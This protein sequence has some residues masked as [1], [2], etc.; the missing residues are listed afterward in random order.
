MARPRK[1]ST[2]TPTQPNGTDAYARPYRVKRLGSP[3]A[4][5]LQSQIPKALRFPLYT[6]LSLS[7]STLVLQLFAEYYSGGEMGAISQTKNTWPEIGVLVGWRVVELGFVW[8]MGYDGD[9]FSPFIF[10]HLPSPYIPQQLTSFPRP[11]WDAAYFATLTHAPPLSLLNTFYNIRPTV[12]IGHLLIDVLALAI[13]LRL[14]RPLSPVHTTHPP[15]NSVS[16]RGI[17]TDS[18]TALSTALLATSIYALT[19]YAAYSTFL[20]EYM[21][22][23]FDLKT[24]VNAHK[25]ASGLPQIVLSCLPIDAKN[26]EPKLPC[27]H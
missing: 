5:P 24:L 14:L 26:M 27:F 15:K 2:G 9:S 21:V 8:G 25:G 4:L 22:T 11:A 6:L 13:P 1:T 12:A 23:R 7:L 10:S 17:L 3:A 20:P 16:N 18:P 19:L